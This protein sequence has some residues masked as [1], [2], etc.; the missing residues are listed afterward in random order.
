[1]AFKIKENSK[2]KHT[3]MNIE[4]KCINIQKTKSQMYIQRISE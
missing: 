2:V 3:G 4:G 1:M